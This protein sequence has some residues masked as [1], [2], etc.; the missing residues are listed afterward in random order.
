ME[1]GVLG[2]ESAC[3]DDP[4]APGF[5]QILHLQKG[6]VIVPVAVNGGDDGR[7]IMSL[8]LFHPGQADVGDIA[9]VHRHGQQQGVPGGNVHVC[10]G[11]LLQPVVGFVLK[12]HGIFD[13]VGAGGSGAL[14]AEKDGVQRH[15]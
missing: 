6:V 8:Q 5:Q 10:R 15:A 4:E 13:A 1:D 7:G 3:G 14:A 11:R 2:K 9:A 12:T